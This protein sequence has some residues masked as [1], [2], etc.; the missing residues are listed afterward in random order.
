VRLN[1][2]SSRENRSV[3]RIPSGEFRESAATL[4]ISLAVGLLRPLSSPSPKTITWSLPKSLSARTFSILKAL[5]VQ[6]LKY[7]SIGSVA[8]SLVRS[9]TGSGVRYGEAIAVQKRRRQVILRDGSQGM[10][11]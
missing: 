2:I 7:S 6:S 10:K 5:R 8:D 1:S 11:F 4:R 9:P 3:G